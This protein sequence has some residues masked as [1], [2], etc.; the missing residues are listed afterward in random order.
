M[1]EFVN[2]L[3]EALSGDNNDLDCYLEN[4]ST[5]EFRAEINQLINNAKDTSAIDDAIEVLQNLK[6]NT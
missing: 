4:V 5:E 1:S 2:E 3:E 6:E